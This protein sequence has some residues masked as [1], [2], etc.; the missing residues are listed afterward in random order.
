M[1]KAAS[2]FVYIDLVLIGAG[3]AQI[4]VLKSFGMN[5]V[6]GVRLTLITDVLNT[7]YS[8]M[9]PGYVEGIYSHDDMHINLVRLAR[10]ANARLIN[11]S[12]TDIDF[13][14]KTVFIQEAAPV[15]Y[16]VLSINSGAVPEVNSIEGGDRFGIAVKP[17]SHFL[18]QLP[19][20]D[21]ALGPIAII[22]GGAAGCEL[23][24]ALHHRYNRARN[25]LPL[26][27]IG[28]KEQL[29]PGRPQ[30]AMR[31]I[32]RAL[33]KADITI[34]LGRPV[35]KISKTGLYFAE[36]TYLP[37]SHIFIVTSACP[38]PWISDLKLTHSQD[39][40]IAVRASLQTY[41]YEQVFAAG[42]VA[43]LTQFPREKAGVFAVRAGPILEH[44]IRALIQGR[45]LRNWSPQAQYLAIIGLGQ[46]DALALRGNF[47]H[48]GRFWWRF[49]EWI[50]RRFMKT[51]TALPAMQMDALPA[52]AL[53]Q[54]IEPEL[55]EKAGEMMFCAACG[56][57]TDPTTLE[58]ALR[59][60]ALIAKQQGADDAY[61]PNADIITDHGIISLGE[62]G[63]SAS[64]A[65]ISQSID[66]ISQH[67]SDPFDFGR[68]AALH[69]LSD[70]FVAGHQ[71]ISALAMVTLARGRQSLLLSDLTQMLS[72]SLIELAAHRTHLI[73]GHTATAESSSLGFAVTG[74]MRDAKNGAQ[75]HHLD[76]PGSGV[77]IA[78]ILTKPLGIGVVLAAEM[79]Q[80]CSAPSYDAAL[81]TMLTSNAEAARVLLSEDYACL[82]TDVTG[83]GLAR[84]ARN[85]AERAGYSG[86]NIF[87][88]RL[89][90]LCDAIQL[91]QAGIRSSLYQ[92]NRN[93]V[94]CDW[95][96]G[97][98][99]VMK[100]KA[101]LVFD[102]QTSGGILAAVP[103]RL[104]P[105]ICAK[106]GEAGY[107]QSAIIGSLSAQHSQVILTDHEELA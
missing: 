10:F 106:L 52:P 61:L 67:I 3:H 72:G 35:S 40:F 47:V 86:V 11:K 2:S 21:A 74:M 22:G 13:K 27:L 92:Q 34:H 28:S 81:K 45:H 77:P 89:P 79:R 101:E 58:T 69:A 29:L 1:M 5:P 95:R 55:A 31:L 82:M 63:G 46:G 53:L 62:R 65:P 75:H 24:L 48:Q 36:G 70:I 102:P 84:H 49:K 100:A 23:A 87:L 68:I 16:D 12:V 57:K 14:N 18:N 80:V 17:I 39:G 66:F 96:E 76:L 98:D 38:A 25:P 73:G 56:A 85:L 8:G 78:L 83:F 51:F 42:D 107:P 99:G 20:P 50:D 15:S 19:F 41:E 64:S 91:S 59:D 33:K 26:H 105:D 30:K 44:N 97:S 94:S 103:L 88:D 43:T 9:L 37:A 6:V 54:Q 104:A 93:S 4:A 32:T 7:P 60:A 90:V 71:P